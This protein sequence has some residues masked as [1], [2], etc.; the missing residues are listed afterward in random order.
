M[1]R[2]FILLNIRE[3]Q[4]KTMMRCYA[5]HIRMAM[6]KKKNFKNIKQHVLVRM[7]RNWNTCVLLVGMQKNCCGKQ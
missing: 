1:K 2:C 4:I 3:M 5:V 7:W 6:I